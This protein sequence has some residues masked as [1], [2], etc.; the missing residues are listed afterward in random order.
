MPLFQNSVLKKYRSTQDQNRIDEAFLQFQSYFG[1]PFIRENIRNSK[2]E[3][4]QEGFLRE[5]FVNILGY[6]INPEPD[7]NLTTELKNI[8]DSKKTD[9]AILVPSPEGE[10][11]G[12]RSA[13]AVIELKGTDTKDLEKIRDQAFNYKNNQPDC[14]YVIT[15]NF[16]KLRFYIHNAVD[17]QEFNL[18]QL[19]RSEFELLWLLLQKDNLLSGIPAK[20]KEESLQ[21]EE[22]VTKQLYADYS[23]F[24]Q[25]LWQDMVA[26]N[27]G[28]DEL[29]LYKKSQKLLD[30][31]LFIFFAEDKGL[32][33]PNSINEIIKHWETLE[34]L[35][36]YVPLYDRFKLYFGFMNSGRPAGKIKTEIH[37]YNGGLFA[38]DTLLDTVKI[39]DSILKKHCRKLSEYDFDTEVDTNILGHIFEHS[40]NDIEN[41]RAS[42]EG[43]AIDKSKTKRKKDGVFYTPKYITKYIVDNTLGRLCGEKKI[44]LGIVDEDFA[45]GKRGRQKKTIQQ[46]KGKLDAYRA[47]LLQLTICDPACG[48]GAF[49]NQVLEYLIAEHRYLDELESQLFGTPMVLPNVENQ[50]LENNI[51]GV[52]INEE[53]VE[54]ARLSLW[55]RTAKKGRKL[56]SLNSNIKVGNSLIDDPAVAG[57][58]A[59]N[60]EKEFP[61]V[62]AKGGFDVVVGNPPYVNINTLPEIHEYL[63]ENY[64]EIHTG[65]NDLMYYFI[66]SSINMLNP[67]GKYGVITSNYFL[68]NDYAKGIRKYLSYVVTEIINFERYLIFE[69]ANVHTLILLANKQQE[70]REVNFYTY[71]SKEVL[72][73][74]T[75]SNSNYALAI[76]KREKLSENWVI[77]D[78]SNLHLIEKIEKNTTHLGHISDIAKGSETG[79]NEIFTINYNT[80]LKYNIE[81]QVL[82]KCVKN[83]DIN[84]FVINFSGDYIIYAD[85][86]F[87]QNKFPNA[88]KYLLE[89]KEILLDR[90]GPKTGEY[91]WWRLHRPSI[92]EVFDSNEK[93]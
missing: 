64:S 48:S 29:M 81:A 51:F 14:I 13:L 67:N 34:D 85:N 32:L 86:Y 26:Q 70:N 1:N 56:S 73:E 57:D 69:E 8:K 17:H 50:I 35:D 22:Q 46:L 61:Q 87:D 15:S 41:V 79:K 11:S 77:A 10:E 53:S 63:K 68:G 84:R 30:R 45:E 4:F 16:E 25:E 75:I 72:K 60:W 40:L 19:T 80:I 55:L 71:T 31:F 5:L 36:A 3:Q 88:Y 42:L 90:R 65:Y 74:V 28:E 49:L 38:A 33:P 23:A 89:H 62:F 18:F 37:A 58:L 76:L 12:V 21:A 54:I 24:K 83:S 93:Y 9:G 44:E 7:F 39:S 66:Y 27:P 20:I 82:K 43:T 59:F 47:W 6:T 2:E 91:E 78:K 92:K 52:D